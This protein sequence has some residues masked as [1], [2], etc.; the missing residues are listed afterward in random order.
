MQIIFKTLVVILF[1]ISFF[2]GFL[3]TKNLEFYF[4][5]EEEKIKEVIPVKKIEPEN[6]EIFV[7]M[8]PKINQFSRGEDL[9][10]RFSKNIIPEKVKEKIHFSPKILGKI[11]FPDEKT[12]IFDPDFDSLPPGEE[13]FLKID[14]GNIGENEEKFSGAKFFFQVPRIEFKGIKVN[15]PSEIEVFFNF[16]IDLEIFFKNSE[17]H[18]PRK[19]REDEFFHHPDFAESF[20]ITFFPPLSPD[21]VLVIFPD[22]FVLKN[23]EKFGKNMEKV[24]NQNIF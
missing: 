8:N 10:F 20:L 19:E 12:M 22:M 4:P 9:I 6:K 2:F 1:L 18:P 23:G 17:I 13:I 3:V 16:P 21:S 15:S 24:I 5:Q 7:K 14:N 11:S